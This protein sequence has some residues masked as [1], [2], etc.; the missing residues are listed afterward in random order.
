MSRRI[1]LAQTLVGSA[2]SSSKRDLAR[3]EKK[4][5]LAQA[6]VERER[7][8]AK[9]RIANAQDRELGH[10]DA[11]TD[12]QAELDTLDAAHAVLRAHQ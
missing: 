4:V 10:R 5:E 12:V 11:V 3:A 9:E 8:L 6:K 1:R 2:V 7:E